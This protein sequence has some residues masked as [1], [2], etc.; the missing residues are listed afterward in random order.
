MISLTSIITSP[1][2]YNITQATHA[3]VSIETGLKAIGRPSF[4]LL[5]KNIDQETKK[6]SAMKELLYQLTCMVISLLIVIPLFKKGSFAAARKLFKDEKVFNVF[7]KSDE[8]NKYYRLPQAEKD[9]KLLEIG[10]KAGET[11][12]PADINEHL[13]KGVIETSSIMGSI[14]GLSILSPIIA[15]AI[16]RPALKVMGLRKDDKDAGNDDKKLNVKA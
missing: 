8:F 9:A 15:R 4:I 5:D 13:A 11:I 14:M 10:E 7:N 2:I 3:Q 12:N 16:V 6:Y 1:A